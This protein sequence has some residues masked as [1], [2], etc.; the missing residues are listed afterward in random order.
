MDFSSVLRFQPNSVNRRSHGLTR[1]LWS[2]E[3]AQQSAQQYT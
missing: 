1:S 3:E 2:H